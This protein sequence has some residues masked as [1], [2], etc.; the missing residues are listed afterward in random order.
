MT[1]R[2]IAIH[3]LTQTG[4]LGGWVNPDHRHPLDPEDDAQVV[5]ALTAAGVPPTAPRDDAWWPTLPA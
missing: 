4:V 3:A 5:D 1:D 2:D